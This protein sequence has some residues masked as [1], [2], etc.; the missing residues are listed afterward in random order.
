MG[1]QGRRTGCDFLDIGD[2][3]GILLATT[4]EGAYVG[5]EFNNGETLV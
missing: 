5:C 3:V 4:Q 1:V 2:G